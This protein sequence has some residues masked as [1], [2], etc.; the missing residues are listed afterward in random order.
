MCNASKILGIKIA[1]KIGNTKLLGMNTRKLQI[2]HTYTPIAY[3][4]IRNF[5]IH[6]TK[7]A[8][9]ELH[10]LMQQQS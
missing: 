7:W 9:N 8:T 5:E 10:Y 1:A 2:F 6:E 4:E 3:Q